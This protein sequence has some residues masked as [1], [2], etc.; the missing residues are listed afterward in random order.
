[1]ILPDI[2]LSIG[3]AG[4]GYR[5]DNFVV[6]EGSKDAFLTARSVGDV[7]TGAHNPLFLVG[8]VGS[9]KSHLLGAIVN[10]ISSRRPQSKILCTS[11][12]ALTDS[13]V[14]SIRTGRTAELSSFFAEFDYLILDDLEARPDQP[15]TL[16]ALLHTIA[17]AV[18]RKVQ[19]VVA[20]TASEARLAR[21][22]E[23]QI[24]ARFPQVQISRLRHPNRNA[25]VEIARRISSLRGLRLSS[26]ALRRIARQSSGDPRELHGIINR[27][28]AES[29]LISQ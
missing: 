14:S 15:R 28:A 13:L 21:F 26:A 18:E 9:G 22:L 2:T 10:A 7:T 6:S 24:R 16:E 3:T 23:Q 5:F 4:P 11:G 27:I 25:R 20:S 8:P 1:M 29:S 12:S 17:A 19:V